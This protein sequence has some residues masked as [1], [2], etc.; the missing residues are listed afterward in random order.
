MR[1]VF[2]IFLICSAVT[3]FDAVHA[4]A[5]DWDDILKTYEGDWLFRGDR[6]QIWSAFRQEDG[7]LLFREQFEAICGRVIRKWEIVG[8]RSDGR[9]TGSVKTIFKGERVCSVIG[10]WNTSENTM[11]WSFEG[12]PDYAKV[13][14]RFTDSKIVVT[15]LLHSEN[16]S[17]H[18]W[19]EFGNLDPLQR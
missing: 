6:K 4:Q 7:S 18:T 8:K 5:P 14:H 17:R 3:V 11:T 13:R 15:M 12:D 19:Y 10:E 1:L 16:R 2:A 9:Y